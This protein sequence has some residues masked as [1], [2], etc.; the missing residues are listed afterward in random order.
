[1]AIVGFGKLETLFRKAAGL[2]I[3]KN[4]AKAITDIVEKKLYDLLLIGERN[5]KYN[6]RDVI[7]ECDV[8]LTKG[9]LETIQKFK[10]LEEQLELQDILDFLATQPPL[11]YPLEAELE[12]KLPEIV[13]TLLFIIARI[14][15]TVDEGCRQP[16]TE[17]IERA[18]KILDLTM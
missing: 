1:M 16:S 12:N 13:G 7:W 3:D 18:G 10:E 14:I 8:P 9:F 5:A 11:K 4:K 17:D 6:G 2:D 15:K